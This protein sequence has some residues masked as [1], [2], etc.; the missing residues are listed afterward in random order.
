MELRRT[1]LIVAMAVIGYFLML[2]WQKDYGNQSDVATAALPSTVNSRSDVPSIPAQS[3]RKSSDI[4]SAPTDNV[5]PPVVNTAISA[6]DLITVT[7]DVLQ[8]KID[9]VG[10]DIVYAALPAYTTTAQSKDPFILLDNSVE[11]HFIAQSGLVGPNGPDKEGARAHY[12][13]NSASFTLKN[14]EKT[15]Q[16]TLSLPVEN[17]VEI[18]K[19]FE[20][21]RG[22]YLIKQRYDIINQSSEH[23]RGYTFGQIKRDNSKDPSASKQGFGMSTFLGAAW[24]TPEKSYNKLSLADF[25]KSDKLIDKKVTGGWVA[26]LQHYFVTAWV[27]DAKSNNQISTIFLK[28]SNERLIRFVGDA[29]DVAPGASRSVSDSLYIGPKIQK[30]LAKISDGLELTV[31]YGW[32]WFIAQGLFWL[33]VKI[34]AILGNWGWA[35]IVLTLLVKLVFFQLSAT[36]YKSM[37]HMRRVTPEIQRI[38]EQYSNDRA[39]MSQAMMEIYKKEKIN[40]LGGCLPIVVQM[41]VFIALYSTLMESVELRHAPWILW[42]KD[43]S[44]MDPYYVLPLIM[45]ASMFMQQKMNPAP[46]DPTQAKVM[47]MMPIIF[48]FMF[49]WFPAG[50]TL[51][52]VVNN[53]LSILQQW[54]ITRQIQKAEGKTA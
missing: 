51:Y 45:G 39:K 48:T 36:S 15:L 42:I 54:I 19:V 3:V 24:W 38:R 47:K 23:W 7:T 11:R 37:A 26:M 32:L 46:P 6:T 8:L 41:P 29:I 20:L 35:I 16:V 13:A 28:D 25:S 44:V 53:G 34:H 9:P 14:G 33:L 17:G 4:P 49:L 18:H 27:P 43:L 2:S 5:A 40:P 52:W 22:S 10:G 12:Q 30:N 50:L 31:D 1:L 21:E